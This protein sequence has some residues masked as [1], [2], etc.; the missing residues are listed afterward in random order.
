MVIFLFQFQKRP[1]RLL[2]IILKVF[3][4]YSNGPILWYCAIQLMLQVCHLLYIPFRYS[5]STALVVLSLIWILNSLLAVFLV[6]IDGEN[7]ND[8]TNC[9]KNKNEHNKTNCD[10]AKYVNGKAQDLESAK[11]KDV[12]PTKQNLSQNSTIPGIS[13]INPDQVKNP[14]LAPVFK[15][16]PCLLLMVYN[17]FLYGG[18]I[19]T[20]I[21]LPPLLNESLLTKNHACESNC[22]VNGQVV[23][24]DIG[25]L[26][27]TM[28]G[29]GGAME[30]GHADVTTALMMFGVG[31]IV[32]IVLCGIV[33]NF[34]PLADKHFYLF[35]ANNVVMLLVAGKGFVA[36]CYR[37]C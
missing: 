7:E 24:M 33:M 15:T 37:N 1:G 12:K 6:E 14:M 35:I 18:M 36:V 16:P 5:L 19:G 31:G 4:S 25:H 20:V 8:E 9:H 21:F 34:G 26:E 27:V 30:M 28:T 13:L 10:I 3:L 23:A 29:P 11:G 32:G 17:F 22:T 2:G